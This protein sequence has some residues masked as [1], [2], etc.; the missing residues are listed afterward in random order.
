[1]KITENITLYHCDY[2]KKKLF[3][4]GSMTRHEETCLNNPKN[5]KACFNCI[6][7]EKTEQ[8]VAWG[9][10]NPF[11]EMGSKKIE[12]FKC[13]KLDKLMFPYRI[14]RKKLHERFDTYAN[15]EPM[16][17]SKG[18]LS[19]IDDPKGHKEWSIAY[20]KAKKKQEPLQKALHDKFYH[21]YG[22][23]WNGI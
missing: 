10:E 14:E 7:L 20:E 9:H 8:E 1:M 21:Q 2:C 13:S 5:H 23:E 19:C 22:I 17:P 4:K 12:M 3:R 16:P 11:T 15:Q 6:F 18:I